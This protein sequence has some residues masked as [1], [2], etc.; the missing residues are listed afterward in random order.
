MSTARVELDDD[1]LTRI[2][3]GMAAVDRAVRHG[4][5]AQSLFA[6]PQPL[7]PTDVALQLG[8]RLC[9]RCGRAVERSWRVERGGEVFHPV[10]IMVALGERADD[11]ALS[12]RGRTS[13]VVVS[14]PSAD[15]APSGSSLPGRGAAGPRS[16][17]SELPDDTSKA[18]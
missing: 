2:V 5:E 16:A 17:A 9:A 11:D 12:Y 18:A 14:G 15:A 7:P 8:W 3:R 13:S 4:A 1:G 6:G 10:C